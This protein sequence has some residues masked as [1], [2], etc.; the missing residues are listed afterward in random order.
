MPR[1]PV[2]LAV[3]TAT[4]VCSAALLINGTI[5]TL[6]REVGQRHTEH[7]LAL[8]DELLASQSQS[9]AGCDAIAFGAGP[10]SF[11]GLRVACGVAQGLAYGVGRPV[12][13][14]ANLAAAALDVFEQHADA[15]TVLIAQDARMN[16]AYVG[17][18][19]K[20]D[21]RLVERM[22][23]S[24]AAPQDLVALAARYGADTIAGT[25]VQVFQ[26]HLQAFVGRRIGGTVA[27]AGSIAKL[28]RV[29]FEAGAAIEPAAAAPLY[30]RDRVALTVD[31]RRAR[32]G[33]ISAANA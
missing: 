33:P 25:A 5:H 20:N 21:D 4:S 18:Y 11:T 22:S 28:A 2:L 30:V 15:R 8:I 1:S 29:A 14:I 12:V 31:E 9:L 6:A 24:L 3:D 7:V 23:P 17:A 19:A 16:E 13:P 32:S 26:S 27:T 10:G